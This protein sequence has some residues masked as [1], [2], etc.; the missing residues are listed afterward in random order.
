MPASWYKGLMATTSFYFLYLVRC[1]P[2]DELAGKACIKLLVF[3]DMNLTWQCYAY[4]FLRKEEFCFWTV[5]F[6]F[7][8]CYSPYMFNYINTAYIIT[9]WVWISW[10]FCNNRISTPICLRGGCHWESIY[11]CMSIK[12]ITKFNTR[13]RKM[14]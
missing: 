3:T 10:V 8:S 11:A 4:R 1:R 12:C 5:L 2:S 9:W 13:I 7:L 14:E 6:F